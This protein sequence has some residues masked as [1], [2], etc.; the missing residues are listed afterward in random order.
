MVCSRP[1][2]C[3]KGMLAPAWSEWQQIIKENNILFLWYLRGLA[4]NEESKLMV[5]KRH[6][7]PNLVLSHYRSLLTGKCYDFKVIVRR[8]PHI[9]NKINKIFGS[10][11]APVY[12]IFPS[13][14]FLIPVPSKNPKVLT[15]SY[16]YCSFLGSFV[17]IVS[18][19]S[20][21]ILLEQPRVT[22]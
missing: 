9:L 1:K 6:G 10:L 3:L 22:H 19:I 12:R 7:Q 16:F 15:K 11:G 17:L 13:N 5:T 20:Y 18:S 21:L 2:I 4:T 14:N 8:E